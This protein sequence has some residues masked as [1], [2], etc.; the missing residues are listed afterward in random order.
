MPCRVNSLAVLAVVAAALMLGSVAP[1]DAQQGRYWGFNVSGVAGSDLTVNPDTP[2]LSKADVEL[3][4]GYGY[5]LVL[6]FPAANPLMTRGELEAAF[7]TTDI[8]DIGTTAG[9]NGNS[10]EAKSVV[11]NGYYDFGSNRPGSFQPY[12]GGG[13]GWSEVQLNDASLGAGTGPG[14]TALTMDDE[15]EAL[16]FQGMAG[17]RWHLSSATAMVLGYK[18]TGTSKLEFQD[19]AGNRNS[20]SGLKD[21]KVDWGMQFNF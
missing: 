21:H 17:V 13:I 14:G 8:D 2:G 12:L 15:D 7:R 20:L 18:Y 16:T 11:F 3:K 4:D 10:I 1:A 9:A 6:G 19:S 5:G